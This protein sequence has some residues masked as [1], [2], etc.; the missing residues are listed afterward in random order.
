MIPT[1]STLA[2]EYEAVTLSDGAVISVR[3]LTLDDVATL[4]RDHAPA[5]AMSLR[6][7]RAE[8]G[9]ALLSLLE[10][11]PG[12][13]A[14]LIAVAADAPDQIE[15]AR[16]LPL[17]AVMRVLTTIDRLTFGPSGERRPFADILGPLLKQHVPAVH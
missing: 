14:Q 1:L 12:A 6:S 9:P 10:I 16:R 4:F 7:F 13:V 8:P 15:T 5:V 3:A 11:V 17:G 2:V